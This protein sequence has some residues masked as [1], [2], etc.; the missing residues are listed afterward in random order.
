MNE[1]VR[2]FEWDRLNFLPLQP[3]LPSWECKMES[4]YGS[5]QEKM[6]SLQSFNGVVASFLVTKAFSNFPIY[7]T[8]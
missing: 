1:Q 8:F 5:L 4:F 3:C 2:K 7:K 6:N